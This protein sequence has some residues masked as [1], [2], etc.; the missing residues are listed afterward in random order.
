MYCCTFMYKYKMKSL[1][2][3]CNDFVLLKPITN[4][5]YNLRILSVYTIPACRTSIRYNCFKSV[6]PRFWKSIKHDNQ[7]SL[8]IDSFKSNFK[9]ELINKYCITY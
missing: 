7:N 3:V 8:S 1:P 2:I 9:K 6:G 5:H 4:M